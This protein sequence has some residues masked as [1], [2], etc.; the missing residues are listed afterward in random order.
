VIYRWSKRPESIDT[1]RVAELAR[2]PIPAARWWSL[3]TSNA[4]GVVTPTAGQNA[5]LSPEHVAHVT[6]WLIYEPGIS[7]REI[8]RRL[9]PGT[10]GGGD[11]STRAKAVRLLAEQVLEEA[12]LAVR[13]PNN[14]PVEAPAN[15]LT[16]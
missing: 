15:S 13:T 3:P 11:Y 16:P 10:D 6:T 7:T 12:L 8:A 5:A 1:T 14:T 2:R 9:Y 4:L